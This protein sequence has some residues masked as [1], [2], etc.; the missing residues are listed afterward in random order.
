[1]ISSWLCL[2]QIHHR[3]LFIQ[4]VNGLLI[5]P[6]GRLLTSFPSLPAPHNLGVLHAP[7][8]SPLTLLG[9]YGSLPEHAWMCLE[10]RRFPPSAGAATGRAVGAM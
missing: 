2:L 1:M 9:F 4:E 8:D 6:Y 5:F 3:S 7:G 10:N